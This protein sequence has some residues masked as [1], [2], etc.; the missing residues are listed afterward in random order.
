MARG[1]VLGSADLRAFAGTDV[2]VGLG[3][4][5]QVTNAGLLGFESHVLAAGEFARPAGL[6]DALLAEISNAEGPPQGVPATRITVLADR[7]AGNAIVSIR[8]ASEED[9]HKGAAVLEAMSPPDAG[10]MKRL[11]VEMYEVVLDRQVP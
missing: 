5:L 10:S 8:F 2:T 1:V 7:A 9:M 11:S 4:A 3:A 6:L